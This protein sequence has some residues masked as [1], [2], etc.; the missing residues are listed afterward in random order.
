VARREP[1]LTFTLDRCKRFYVI[2]TVVITARAKKDLK[3]VPEHIA[4]KL[5][6]WTT[7]VADMGLAETSKIPGYHDEPLKGDRRGQ[8]SIRLNRAYRA[9]YEIRGG[10]VA[11][12]SIEE[13]NKHE[14]RG[15]AAMGAKKAK[16]EGDEDAGEFFTREYGKLTIGR[17]LRSIRLSDEKTLDRF[18]KLLGVSISYLSDVELGRRSVSVE[19]A[20]QWA[21]A[22]GYPEKRFVELALQSELDAAGIALQVTVGDPGAPGAPKPLKMR[23][24]PKQVPAKKQAPVKRLSA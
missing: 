12:V 17:V 16:R 23:R 6:D 4:L 20:S 24:S 3:K 7:M 21:K 13:V 18:S 19:R 15:E 1:S 22:L 5:A 2:K 9:I 10:D 11:F 8:R 14:Y